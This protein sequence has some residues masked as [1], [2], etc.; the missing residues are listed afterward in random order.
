M[1]GVSG[2]DLWHL[3]EKEKKNG[4]PQCYGTGTRNAA[5]RAAKT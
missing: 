4:A 5:G 1:G 2:F 3:R